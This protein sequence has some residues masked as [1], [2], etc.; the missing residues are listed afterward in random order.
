MDVG[1]HQVE[2]PLHLVGLGLGLGLGFGFGLGLG[3]T[4]SLGSG[5]A[6]SLTRSSIRRTEPLNM[7]VDAMPPAVSTMSAIC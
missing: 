7:P 4:L 3:L 1:G 5:L 6:L 2:H